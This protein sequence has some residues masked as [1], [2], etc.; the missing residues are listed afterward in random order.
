MRVVKGHIDHISRKIK[1]PF[2]NSQ[3][4]ATLAFHASRKIK[5]NILENHGSWQLWKS[6]FTRTKL[7]ISH[8]TGKKKGQ[9]QVM[10]IP[11]TTLFNVIKGILSEELIKIMIHNIY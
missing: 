7:A 2:H 9:S 11:F 8:F 3:K 5:E 4:N 10:K 6:R 1:Q